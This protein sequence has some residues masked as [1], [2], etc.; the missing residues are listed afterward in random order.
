MLCI[1]KPSPKVLSVLVDWAPC[2]KDTLIVLVG[3]L[4]FLW[5]GETIV[6]P[7][8]RA[9]FG[10]ETES[11][12]HQYQEEHNRRTRI[13]S[14][15]KSGKHVCV[16][17]L[18]SKVMRL[19]WRAVT[20]KNNHWATGIDSGF[21]SSPGQWVNGIQW[22]NRIELKRGN[23]GPFHSWMAM[24]QP[25]DVTASSGRVVPPSFLCYDRN[26][27]TQVPCGR[28]VA[29]YARRSWGVFDSWSC[30]PWP[31]GDCRHRRTCV[32]FYMCQYSEIRGLF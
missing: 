29:L 27:S 24:S 14:H 11:L 32:Y 17:L 19:F 23:M 22:V 4:L 28:F 31:W 26:Q 25:W 18:R 20:R 12:K 30:R 13:D 6:Y 9:F 7:K 3:I 1:R 16:N 10:K 15:F 21:N 8:N 5:W 2:L